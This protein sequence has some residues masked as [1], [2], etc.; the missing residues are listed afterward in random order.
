MAGLSLVPSLPV[1]LRAFD[2]LDRLFHLGEDL[3]VPH[4]DHPFRRGREEDNL[5]GHVAQTLAEEDLFVNPWPHR[6]TGREGADLPDPDEG[7]IRA[8]EEGGYQTHPIAHCRDWTRVADGRGTD[9]GPKR[10]PQWHSEES[11]S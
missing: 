7:R 5:H 11:A 4:K 9:Q 10:Q 2:P 1:A 3:S 8:S 6:D